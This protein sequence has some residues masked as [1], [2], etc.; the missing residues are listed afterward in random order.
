[1]REYDL[2]Q[3][4]LLLN[5]IAAAL[6]WF[7]VLCGVLLVA[8]IAVRGTAAVLIAMLVPFTIL[9]LKRALEMHSSGTPFC[10][11]RFDCGCGA[12]EVYIC[13][14]LAENVALVLLSA[15]LLSGR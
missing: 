10:A 6:P 2:V 11:I 3:A 5:S 1:V 14:K 13:N 9:V 4:P 15:W 8:G 7:E 12:G